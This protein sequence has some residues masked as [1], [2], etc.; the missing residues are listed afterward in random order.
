VKKWDV[1]SLVAWVDACAETTGTKTDEGGGLL[2]A[3]S[4]KEPETKRPNQSNCSLTFDQRRERLDDLS[5][6]V[7]NWRAGYEPTKYRLEYQAQLAL[8]L[9]LM[10][11]K[12]RATVRSVASGPHRTVVERPFHI[13]GGFT[14]PGVWHLNIS[15]V[16]GY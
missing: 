14:S 4:P 13:S 16:K 8:I 15:L 3:T 2:F 9:E 12:V 10:P 5:V 11:A 7:W 1:T 6:S